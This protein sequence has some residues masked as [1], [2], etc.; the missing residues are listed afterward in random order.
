MKLNPNQLIRID[1]AEQ[2]MK[3]A[4]R[5]LLDT[6]S[7]IVGECTYRVG[8]KV[9][10]C[11][12]AGQPEQP[13]KVKRVEVIDGAYTFEFLLK[14]SGGENCYSLMGWYIVRKIEMYE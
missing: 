3:A 2:A 5:N 9:M 10:I 13:A 4:N 1:V 7:D 14:G 6:Y 11:K 12:G 8:E